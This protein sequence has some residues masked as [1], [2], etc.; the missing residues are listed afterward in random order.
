M[1]ENK[2]IPMSYAELAVL[3]KD[4]AR[5]VEEGD[6]F[7]GSLEYLVP[8]PSDIDPPVDVMVRA[9]YRHGNSMGQGGVRIIGTAGGR[10]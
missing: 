10:P 3:L 6:S 7:E 8:Y 4:M 5:V 1:Q 2:H 9:V